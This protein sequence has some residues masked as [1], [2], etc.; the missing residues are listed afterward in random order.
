[1][2]DLFVTDDFDVRR[3]VSLFLLQVHLLNEKAAA[4][5]LF[6]GNCSLRIPRQLPTSD[7]D[8]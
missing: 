1:M 4:P 3:G 6:I 8:I 5:H 2:N 7:E